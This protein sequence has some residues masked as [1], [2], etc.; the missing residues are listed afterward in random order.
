MFVR[1]IHGS[2]P[3]PFF[4]RRTPV[5]PERRAKRKEPNYFLFADKPEVM[6]GAVI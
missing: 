3:N 2:F 1:D 4:V 6:D 5:P